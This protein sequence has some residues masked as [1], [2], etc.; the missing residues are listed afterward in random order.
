MSDWAYHEN[1]F[2]IADAVMNLTSRHV[3]IKDFEQNPKRYLLSNQPIQIEENGEVIGA[4]YP[5]K[6][7]NK[8]ELDKLLDEF[9]QATEALLTDSGLTREELADLLDVKKPFPYEAD[10]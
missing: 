6:R 9:E 3:S 7:K 10:C 1:I 5:K 4:Y 2:H 8:E